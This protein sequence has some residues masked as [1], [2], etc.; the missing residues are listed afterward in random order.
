MLIPNLP[1]KVSI[2]QF[3]QK[4]PSNSFYID[5]SGRLMYLQRRRWRQVSVFNVDGFIDREGEIV[6][7]CPC[8]W[9]TRI[10]WVARRYKK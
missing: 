1:E 10:K 8:G 3:D 4:F 7:S 9:T 6:P 5:C 2:S